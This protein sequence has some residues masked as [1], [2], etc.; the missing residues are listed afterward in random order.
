MDALVQILP[1]I[2]IVVVF[3]FLIVRPA[4]KKQQ[5]LSHLRSSV[6]IGDTVLLGSGIYGEVET[7]TDDGLRVE[8]APGVVVRVHRDAVVSIEKPA[9]TADETT[10]E[11]EPP[12][13]HQEG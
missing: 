10:D 9:D 5:A 13:T 7:V 4:R 3:W 12:A 8:I 2:L 6:D 1:L 11:S